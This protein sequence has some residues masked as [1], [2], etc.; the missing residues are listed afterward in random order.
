MANPVTE[1][2]RFKGE[3]KESSL[4][5]AYG[6]AALWLLTSA[7]M[8]VGGVFLWR[9]VNDYYDKHFSKKES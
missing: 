8:F 2:V 4:A 9:V 5:G 6:K 1:L 7:A 3:G